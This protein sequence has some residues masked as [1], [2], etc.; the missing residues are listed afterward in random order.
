MVRSIETQSLKYSQGGLT[1]VGKPPYGHA[2]VPPTMSVF[3]L[4]LI[5]TVNSKRLKE[6]I[7]TL[8]VIPFRQGYRSIFLVDCAGRPLVV[9]FAVVYGAATS[10]RNLKE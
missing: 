2:M 5:I 1:I 4:L 6:T 9:L 7:W 3:G 8:L 10:T